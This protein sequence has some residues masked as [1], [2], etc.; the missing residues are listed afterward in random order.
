MPS[1]SKKSDGSIPPCSR[2]PDRLG[3]RARRVLRGDVEVAAA[4]DVRGDHVERAVVVADRRRVD[5]ARRPRAFCEG[6]LAV[7]RQDVPELLPVHEVAAREDGH[8]GEELEAAR[9]EVEVPAHADD[10]RVR[11]EAGDDRVAVGAD[12]ASSAASAAVARTR[13]ASRAFIAL[14][15]PGRA[16]RDPRPVVGAE[17][18]G[19]QALAVAQRGLGVVGPGVADGHRLRHLGRGD[20]DRSSVD[21]RLA[22]CHLPVGPRRSRSAF[23]AGPVG[24]REAVARARSGPAPRRPPT[25]EDS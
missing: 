22:Q 6:Q 12:A 24:G 25:A 5:A 17:R 8:P 20:D 21:A 3:P 13:T 15:R 9:D 18:R 1:S 10:A 16:G 4:V 19:G 23:G 11:V 2:H 7:A 14:L